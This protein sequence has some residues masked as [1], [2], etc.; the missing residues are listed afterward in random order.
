MHASV[1]GVDPP[2]DAWLTH[3]FDQRLSEID[4]ACKGSGPEA[5][6]LFE[7]WTTT[8]GRFF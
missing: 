4:A 2:L 5:L 6:S 8:Y 1:G 3:Y 7:N